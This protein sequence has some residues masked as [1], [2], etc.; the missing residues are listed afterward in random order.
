MDTLF[1]IYFWLMQEQ[2]ISNLGL[3]ILGGFLLYFLQKVQ[4]QSLEIYELK[5]KSDDTKEYCLHL[6]KQIDA[7]NARNIIKDIQA[8]NIEELK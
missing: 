8:P 1:L 6:Q 2:P 7:I 5:C 3:L 4:S